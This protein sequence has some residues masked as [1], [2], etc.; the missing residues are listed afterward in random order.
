ML[1]RWLFLILLAL[2]NGGID[3]KHIHLGRF[4]ILLQFP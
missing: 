4:L 2:I 3:E 1:V